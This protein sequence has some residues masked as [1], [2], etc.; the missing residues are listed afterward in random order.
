MK[1]IFEVIIEIG[2]LLKRKKSN[3]LI[4]LS[5]RRN[6]VISKKCMC[7]EITILFIKH[8]VLGDWFKM[9]E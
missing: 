2:T 5:L 6:F 1:I 8:I 3:G 7:H 9:A 4:I